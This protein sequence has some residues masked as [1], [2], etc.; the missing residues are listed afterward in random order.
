M[1]IAMAWVFII[2]VWSVT[3]V[4]IGCKNAATGRNGASKPRRVSAGGSFAVNGTPFAFCE[5]GVLFE[6]P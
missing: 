2:A 4:F 6:L 1:G 3:I 5:A